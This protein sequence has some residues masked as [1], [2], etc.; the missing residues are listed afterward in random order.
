MA[1]HPSMVLWSSE[2]HPGVFAPM[3]E[4]Y[5]AD[6]VSRLT[7]DWDVP[8]RPVTVGEP[9][10]NTDL[11]W[12]NM[13]VNQGHTLT[14]GTPDAT[15]A[16]VAATFRAGAIGSHMPG[17]K[18]AGADPRE[19]ERQWRALGR[20]HGV[21]PLGGERR[22]PARIAVSGLSPG[23][24]VWASADWLP[25]TGGVA[26]AD[27]TASMDIWHRGDVRLDVS[28]VTRTVTVT[29]GRWVVPEASELSGNQD[30]LLQAW[31]GSVTPC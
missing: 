1:N 3:L 10:K 15:L 27:G 11:L 20:E 2:G 19:V 18:L 28:G 14:M 7:A 17:Y 25:T 4:R 22:G 29:P 23:Q 16:T 13:E 24:V 8:N 31:K 26:D 21:T 30:F 5:A 9:V 6:P 12:W